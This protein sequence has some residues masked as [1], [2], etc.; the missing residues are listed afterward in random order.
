MRQYLQKNTLPKKSLMPHP[1]RGKRKLACQAAL[2]S[3]PVLS[4]RP[5]SGA[6]AICTCRESERTLQGTWWHQEDSAS[7]I[8]ASPTLVVE[9]QQ[10]CQNR[11]ATAGPPKCWASPQRLPL[12]IR[13]HARSVAYRSD[14]QELRGWAQDTEAADLNLCSF[15]NPERTAANTANT[16]LMSD[17]ERAE[18]LTRPAAQVLQ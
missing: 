8:T 10:W 2:L 9:V 4:F 13:L 5:H 3:W 17:A 11:T 18:P 6:E 16:Y 1:T 15:I 14:L 12:C 7:I